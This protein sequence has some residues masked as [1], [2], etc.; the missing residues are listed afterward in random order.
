MQLPPIPLFR[1]LIIVLRLLIAERRYLLGRESAC[2]Q[3]IL[4]LGQMHHRF[5]YTGRVLRTAY[6]LAKTQSIERFLPAHTHSCVGVLL[7]ICGALL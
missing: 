1:D 3:M 4:L 7:T 6:L 2:D 5:N